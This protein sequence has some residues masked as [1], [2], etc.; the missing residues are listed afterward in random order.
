MEDSAQTHSQMSGNRN[1]CVVRRFSRVRI[2]RWLLKRL[3][4][5]ATSSPG[6]A[7]PNESPD[8]FS[9]AVSASNM[10]GVRREAA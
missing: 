3:F 10:M 6:N 2:E 7:M 9:V 4:D 1:E 5:I 8:T